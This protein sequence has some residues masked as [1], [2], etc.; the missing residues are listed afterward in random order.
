MKMTKL[1]MVLGAL[2]VLLR[3]ASAVGLVSLPEGV[4]GF[5]EG[6]AVG[7]GVAVAVAWWSLRGGG[8]D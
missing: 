5:L 1:L 6:F 2:A 4:N 7:V 8:S 3:L